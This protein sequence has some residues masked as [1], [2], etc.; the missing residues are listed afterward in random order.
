MNREIR[1][2]SGLVALLL[3]SA[4]S[5]SGSVDIGHGQSAN[6]TTDFGIAYIKRTLPADPVALDALRNLDDLTRQ[7]RF[8]SKADVYVRDKASPS[9]VE[10]NVTTR[11]TGTDLYD[12]KDLDVSADGK[13]LVFAMRGPLDPKQKDFDPPTW[14]IWEYD[15]TADNLHSLT[16][17]GTA[18]Q[19]QD[20]SPHYLTIDN[21][22]PEGRVLITSTRQR[23]SKQVLLLEEQGKGGFEAQTEDGNE[24]AFT[25]NVLDPT[26]TGVNAFEQISYNQSHDLNPTV[27]ANGRILFTRWDHAPGGTNGMHLYTMNPDG[28]DLELL[29]GAHSHLVGS[30]DPATGQPSEVQFVKAREMEDG[31]VLALIRPTGSGTDFGGNLVILDVTKSVECAQRTLAAGPG[32]VGTNP[33][34]AQAAATSNDVR[35][36]PGPSPGGRFNS[37]YP[38]WDR[39][40]RVLVSWSECRLIDS[41]GAIVACTPANLAVAAPQIAPPLYS[42]WLFNPVDNT[43]K[44]I[45]PPVEGVMLTDIVSLQARP[46]PAYVAPVPT[47]NPLADD[48]LGIIDIR[49]VYDWADAPVPLAT[50]AETNADVITRLTATPADLRAAR[51]LRIEKAV[52]MGDKDL[53]DGFPDFDRNIALDNSVGYMREI[54][55]YV[56]IEADGSVRVKVPANVAFQISVLDANARRL[57]GFA[58]HRAWLELRPGEVLQ[59]N[60]CH[61]AR[62]PANT[63]HGRSGLFASANA[64]DTSGKTLAQVDPAYA[65]CGASACAAALNYNLIYTGKGGAN[66]TDIA[67][68]YNPGLSTAPPIT[69]SCPN[70]WTAFCRITIDYAASGT[71][72]TF[73]APAHIH[74]LW[75][76]DRGVTA[77]NVSK[78][79]TSC[80][81]A[82]RTQTASCTPVG[83]MTAVTVT[84]GVAP[85]GG[86]ELDADP[87]QQATA[88]LRAYL[89]LV[90][91]HTTPNFDYDRATCVPVRTDIQVPGSIASG[92]AAA[93][94]FFAVLSGT[95][96]GNLNHSG[97]MTPAELRLLSEWVDIGAQYYN[98]P[99]AAPLNN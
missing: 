69:G 32:P 16:D 54:L 14:R 95:S 47:N 18:A 50:G 82:T 55:G 68:K 37:A 7:R 58:Q 84:F 98:N 67:L 42:A 46:P 41:T 4:C 38:L 51:F 91:T 89:Q 49:S 12:I 94:P 85:D 87:A 74:P 66:D 83:T 64:G 78:T 73:L 81:T 48:K 25:L 44:P 29:Y 34:P 96:A 45:V 20:V 11:V 23:Y 71:G 36:I 75:A 53:N 76:L 56:P 92:S 2:L 60:G 33:C 99:F 30:L 61:A 57:P 39:T 62:P 40:D 6:T 70:V 65:N 88:Q 21:T 27:M 63:S 10:R 31:R 80:H 97:F 17:D 13:R 59:C 3:M 26:S 86:L 79:C 22:H 9:G 72:A 93:S 35:T 5:S 43:F 90:T 28:T 77:A 15:I 8:W 19:G 24:S 52:S 1:L